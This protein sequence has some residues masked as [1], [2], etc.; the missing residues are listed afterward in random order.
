MSEADKA[1]DEVVDA[2]VVGEPSTDL[3]P[4]AS[5]GASLFR[6]DD[7]VE[8]IQKATTVANVLKGVCKDQGLIANIGGK[9]HPQVEAW[10]TLGAMLS[11]APV[12][13]WVRPIAWPNPVP[14][15]LKNLQKRGLTFGYEASFVAT[16][17]DGGV[18]GGGEAMCTR[19]ETKWK[20]KDD[21]ALKS[22][23]QTRA[24]S[25]ALAAPL[26]FVMTL[27]GYSGTP[28]EEMD[29]AQQATAARPEGQEWGPA[30]T[31]EQVG[32]ARRAIAYLLTVEPGDAA[33]G[34]V[35]EAVMKC[36]DTYYP[37]IFVNLVL[38]I[39]RAVR[40]QREPAEEP[41]EG[42]PDGETAEERDERERAEAL[43]EE[44]SG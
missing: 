31:P 6:T 11:V 19:T 14:E 44:N 39:A 29:A 34:P 36:G 2:T 43:I 25:K 4:T 12:K 21:Y 27:A 7:P 37:L 20:D 24:T 40:K 16:R 17:A 23:A 3:V 26:R 32:Q 8:V 38:T 28:A 5:Q 18:I 13:E 42:N 15:A 33:V 35:A 30:A 41:G 10:Q 9:E 1:G 22:M